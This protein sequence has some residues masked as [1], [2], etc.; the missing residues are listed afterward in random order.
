MTAQPSYPNAD[1]TPPSIHDWAR[2]VT[3][4]PSFYYR[5]RDLAELKAFLAELP[6]S[7]LLPKRVRMLGGLHSCADI[8]KSDAILDVNA[9]PQ[10]MEFAPDASAVTVST[11][12]HLHEFL[13]ELGQRGKSISATGGTDHQTLAGLI[14]TSTA[15]ATPKYS[16]Y[17]LLEWV[18]YL[19]WDANGAVVECR[20]TRGEPAFRAAICSL[21]A[22]GVLT[23]AHFKLIDQLY[24]RTI[25]KIESLD[26]MLGDLEATSAKYDFWRIDW[27]PDSKKGLVW[28][29]TRIPKAEADPEGDYKQDKAEGLLKWL[30]EKWDQVQNSGALLDGVMEGVYDV[31][32]LFY[33]ETEATG[34]L[35]NMLPVDRRAPLHAAM[36]EWS[37][38]PADLAKVIAACREYFKA[39]GWPNLPIEIELT[40][41]NDFYMSPWNWPGLEHIVKFNFMYLTDVL[42]KPGET[43]QMLTHL[44]GRWDHFLAEGI[45]F[46][47]HWGKLN[48]IGPKFARERYQLDEFRPYVQPAL[49]NP[50]LRERLG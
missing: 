13:A 41:T 33:G 10:T 21:G 11:N 9:L 49:L 24:F 16:L 50:Y 40:K 48:F 31:M 29:A 22:I 37:F 32:A 25:Q 34:P 19:T 14:S 23:R 18:E 27:I 26:E 38:A 3:F 44:R 5:P 45:P 15:P 12:W 42:T 46:K 7:A 47:A 6:R 28:A 43:E 39:S 4:A 1:Q 20:A 17:D 2:L 8:C 30:F 35:R 36:A